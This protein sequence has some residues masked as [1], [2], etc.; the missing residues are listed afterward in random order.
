MLAPGQGTSMQWVPPL[1]TPLYPVLM[2]KL[3]WSTITQPT[4]RRAHVPRVDTSFAIAR[5]YCSVE[6][7]EPVPVITAPLLALGPHDLDHLLGRDV[8][9]LGPRVA[10]VAIVHDL[11]DHVEVPLVHVHRVGMVQVLAAL[12]RRVLQLHQ[13]VHELVEL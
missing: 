11:L 5:K 8:R 2:T 7:R 13:L 12:Q 9:H 6:G 4:L 1:G 10:G 3:W